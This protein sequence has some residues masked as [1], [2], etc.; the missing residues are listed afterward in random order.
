MDVSPPV[1]DASSEFHPSKDRRY[2]QVPE[3]LIPSTENLLDCISR[4]L[5][6]WFDDVC[7]DL[8]EGK[9]LLISIHGNSIRALVKHLEGLSNEGRDGSHRNYQGGDSKWSSAGLHS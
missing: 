9:N 4:V 2:A 7:P 6:C 5:P 8:Y 3:Q 1:L